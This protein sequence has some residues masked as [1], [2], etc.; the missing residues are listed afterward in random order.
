MEDTAQRVFRLTPAVT[1]PS[2]YQST[3]PVKLEEGSRQLTMEEKGTRVRI[4]SKHGYSYSSLLSVEVVQ[5]NLRISWRS[6]PE[7]L[8]VDMM[9]LREIVQ[10]TTSD[11]RLH[12]LFQG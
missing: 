10:S 1:G 9:Y 4:V 8:G 11:R 6:N 12:L 5:D 2:G 7:R 3:F